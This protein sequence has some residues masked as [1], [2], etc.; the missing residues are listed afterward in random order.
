M[1]VRAAP[2]LAFFLL[3]FAA[4][5]HDLKVATWNIEWA[6]LRP[7]GD[8]SLPGDVRPKTPED[9]AVLHGYA[10][11]LDA[12][13]V[14]LQEVDGAAVASRIFDPERYALFFI[15]EDVVQRV[16]LAV[17]R[18]IAVTRLSLIHI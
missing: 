6:T 1:R 4:S 13:V 17:R 15:D 2:G 16:G 3:S 5:A 11:R 12:D 18:G 8:P 10:D 14:A 7:A 9:L